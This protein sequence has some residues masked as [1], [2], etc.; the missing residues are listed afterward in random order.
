MR[1]EKQLLLDEIKGNFED[2]DS[3]VIFNYLGLTANAV[4]QFRRQ[5]SILGG[6]LEMVRKRVLIKAAENIGIKLDLEALPGHIGIV[7]A[8]NDPIETAKVVFKFK[9]ENATK[10]LDVLG[11]RFDG[12]MYNGGDVEKLS[13]LPSKDEMRAQLLSV[14]EAPLSQTLSVMEAIVTSVVYCLDNKSKQENAESNS[15]TEVLASSEV[16]S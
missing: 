9:E 4:G 12:K 8:G 3:F 7:F 16:I 15:L 13:K 14:F 10:T 11:G 6:N 1:K 2:F 5:V